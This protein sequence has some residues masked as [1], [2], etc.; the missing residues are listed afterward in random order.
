MRIHEN[1]ER[2]FRILED[3]NTKAIFFIIG[4]IAKT[5]PEL[6]KKI[7]EKYQIGSH[8]MTHQLVWQQSREA[9]FSAPAS[10]GEC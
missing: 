6:V 3:M 4:W 1:E 2:V 8:T 9:F 7:K 10:Y 5:Y